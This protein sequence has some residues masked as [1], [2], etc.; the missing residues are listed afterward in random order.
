MKT[1][2]WVILLLGLA[3]MGA[4]AGFLAHER[5]HQRLGV[6]GVKVIAQSIYDENGNLV[7]T[8]SVYL[9][10]KV[11]DFDSEIVPISKVTL[12]WLPQDTSYGQRQYHSADGF[13]AGMNVVLMGTDRTS[14]H[15]PE[16]CLTGIGVTLDPEQAESVPVSEPHPYTLPIMKLTGSRKVADPAGGEK[17]QRIV[18]LYWYVAD[19]ELTAR[20]G[21]MMRWLA[22][23]MLRD[24]VLQRWA[25]VTCVGSCAPGEETATCN[26]MKGL[27]SAAVPKFQL[28]AGSPALSARN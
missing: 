5:S 28:A 20:K 7:G 22:R 16:W 21:Q 25:Y 18:F 15:R 27:I 13:S 8:N 10:E 14:I 26:R 1:Q 17:V 23:D 4:T 12:G 2:S 19:G 24:G 3:L 9:P 6:P 11:L